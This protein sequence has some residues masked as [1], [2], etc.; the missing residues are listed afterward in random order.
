VEGEKKLANEP[1]LEKVFAQ[2]VAHQIAGSPMLEKVRWTSLKDSQIVR[3]FGEKGYTIS[4]FIV[5]QI[6]DLAGLAKRQMKKTKTAKEALGRDKQFQ[7]IVGLKED[8]QAR[9]L[10]ILSV[11]TKKKE[12]L[13][14][15]YRNG[16][17]YCEAAVEVC[18]HDFPSLAEGRV[19]PHGIYD[20]ILN[21]GYLSIGNSKDTSEFL[22]DN[23]KHYWENQISL[24]YPKA[25]EMLLLM[26]GGGSNSCLHYIVKEDLQNL[27]N[28]L[29][30]TIR[31]AHYPP[32]C[33]KYNPIEHRFFPH[34]QRSWEGVLFSDYKIVKERAEQTTT[35]KGLK[36]VAWINEKLYQSGRKYSADFK[37]TMT[38]AFDELLPKWNY[39]IHPL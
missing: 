4:R 13:G 1:H 16:K 19:V 9:G 29:Q 17:S 14:Q 15:F 6:T 2:I 31:V 37:E 25:K 36:V 33:S 30:M 24:D 32:Y 5:K 28:Q 26:D 27:A 20:V 35:Q 10:P 3:L 21:K 22:C 8:Y 7:R 12:F 23:L 18:D 34:L 39:Q 11:D 38:I